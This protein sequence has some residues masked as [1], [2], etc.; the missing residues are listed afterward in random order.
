M[1]MINYDKEIYL[2]YE[3]EISSLVYILPL[4]TMFNITWNNSNDYG[5]IWMYVA[6]DFTSNNSNIYAYLFANQTNF[7]L[8]NIIFPT[9]ESS[10]NE[11]LVKN[12]DLSAGCSNKQQNFCLCQLKNFKFYFHALSSLKDIQNLMLKDVG[13]KNKLLNS[14]L[15][16]FTSLYIF[17][18]FS[19]VN[20]DLF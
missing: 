4:N 7:H 5:W 13:K 16:C 3:N 20:A 6:F 1:K 11:N 9:W 17:I 19:S 18:L 14:V 15:N 10:A 8:L 12:C 2:L